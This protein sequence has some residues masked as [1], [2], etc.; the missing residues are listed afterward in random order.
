[1][2][3]R[4]IALGLLIVALLAASAG[5]V[6]AGLRVYAGYQSVYSAYTLSCGGALAWSPPPALYLGLYA[7]QPE[8]VHVRIRSGTPALAKVTVSVPGLTLPQVIDSPSDSAFQTLSF[9]PSLLADVAQ[10][11]TTPAGKRNA[12][13]V[14]TAQVGGRGACQAVA[15][16]ALFSRQWMVWRD[17]VTGADTSRYI[18]GWVTPQSREVGALIGKASRRLAEHPELYSDVPALYGYDGGRATPDQTRNQVDALFDTLQSDYHMRYSSDNAPFT[19]SS[20]QLVQAPGDVLTNSSPTG[21]CV[22][23]TV[24]LASAVER[25]GMRPYLVFTSSHAYLGVALGAQPGSQIEYWETSDLNGSSLGS[26]AN[27]DGNDEYAHDRSSHAV[28][29]VVDV[30]YERSQGIEP[31]Q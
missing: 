1:M 8:L 12:Q 14:V 30:A 2:R 18:V 16:L 3:G 25:L 4:R 9:K 6:A 13:I 7:N 17:P 11:N 21:M 20:S 24:I 28:T 27:A 31:I 15:P 10:D 5:Y 26:Q 23:T 29:A 19:T 22:E